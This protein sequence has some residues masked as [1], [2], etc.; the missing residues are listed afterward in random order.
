MPSEDLIAS[1]HEPMMPI[2]GPT[3]APTAGDFSSGF[4]PNSWKSRDLSFD[5]TR[6]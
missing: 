6:M 2:A 1:L 4:S 5:S 3:F